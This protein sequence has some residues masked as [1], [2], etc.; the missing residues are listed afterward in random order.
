MMYDFCRENNIPHS[1]LGKW[2]VAQTDAQ[3]E[4]LIKL[5]EFGKTVG[6]PTSFVQLDQAVKE[7]PFVR[8]KKGILAS[9]TTGIVDS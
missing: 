8:A 7:E 9:P 1:N 6:V 2:I 4:D 3:W 5:H